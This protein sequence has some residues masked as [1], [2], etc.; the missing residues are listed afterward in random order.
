[1]LEWTRQYNFDGDDVGEGLVLDDFGHIY[2]VGYTKSDIG[3]S[4][5]RVFAQTHDATGI[6]QWSDYIVTLDYYHEYS[7]E[8]A[9]GK[10]IA[11]DDSGNFYVTGWETLQAHDPQPWQDVFLGK[12]D[13]TGAMIWIDLVDTY[14]FSSDSFGECVAVDATNRVIIA[15]SSGGAFTD[16]GQ[17]NHGERDVFIRKYDS[18]SDRAVPSHVLWT[19]QFGSSRNDSCWDITTDL[20]GN[21]YLVGETFGT[22]PGQTFRGGNDAFIRKY[23]PDGTVLWT[24]QFGTA[25]YDAGVSIA[26]DPAGN[27]YVVGTTWG[28]LGS[29]QYGD[30][31]VFLRKYDPSGTLLWT[32]QFGTQVSDYGFNLAI[33]DSGNVYITGWT[34]G[35]LAGHSNQG[36]NDVFIRKYGPNGGVVWTHMFGTPTDDYGRDIEV[37]PTGNVFVFGDTG[38]TLSDQSHHGSRDVFLRKYRQ[39][40]HVSPDNYEPD[41]F[42]SMSSSIKRDTRWQTQVRSIAP[43]NDIDIIRFW[44][45]ADNDEVATRPGIYTFYSTGATDVCIEIVDPLLDES[46]AFDDN[47]GDGG[48]F[49]LEYTFPGRYGG[50]TREHFVRIRGAREDTSGVYTLWYRYQPLYTLDAY[51]PDESFTNAHTITM[52][53]HWQTQDRTAWPIYDDDI[54]EFVA[55]EGGTYMFRLATDILYRVDVFDAHYTPLSE[56]L[57]GDSY[58]VYSGNTILELV[59]TEPGTYFLRITGWLDQYGSFDTG[60]YSLAYRYE[61]AHPSPDRLLGCWHFNEGPGF[62]IATDASPYSNDA[63]IYGATWTTGI[64]GYALSF[65]GNDYAHVFS[66]DFNLHSAVTITAW[67]HPSTMR[68]YGRIAAKTHSSNTSPWVLYGLSLNPEGYALMELASDTDRGWAKSAAPIPLHRWTHLAGTYDGQSIKLYING[69]L[70]TT[71]PFTGPL[72]L[73]HEPFS[74]GRS[75]Y[76]RD[77]F[78]GHID[79]VRLYNYALHP[80]A[81]HDLLNQAPVAACGGPYTGEEGTIIT[82]DASASTD[83][84]GNI[85]HYDWVFGDGTVG[86]GISPTHNY[87]QEG[88]YTVTLTVTDDGGLT[89]IHT[90]SVSIHDTQPT[91]QFSATSL[92]TTMPLTIRCIDESSSSDGVTAW[93]WDFGDGTQSHD[94][95]PTHTYRSPNIYRITLTITE[96]DGDQAETMHVQEVTMLSADPTPPTVTVMVNPLRPDVTQ[97]VEITVRCDAPDGVT[98]LHLYMDNRSVQTWTTTGVHTYH[99]GSLTE[100]SHTYYVEARDQTGNTVRDPLT[101]V[102][103]FAVHPYPM[104]WYWLILA[105][106]AVAGMLSLVVYVGKR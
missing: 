51:E 56:E 18:T 103:S 14:A 54:I 62:A 4:G 46:L 36:G 87:S 8:D 22:L 25:A 9:Y 78:Q 32:R 84:D 47:S 86:T 2:S 5:S 72:T 29:Q 106:V 70:E 64:D 68:G 81:I 43:V 77:Y 13:P 52:T 27:S 16:E 60:P 73:N 58:P 31:D 26:I 74:I 59:I 88:I 96:A 80:T 23:D 98:G 67:I 100:G 30:R 38:G 24:R 63:S 48:N 40:Y 10:D 97:P 101:G 57:L 21:I 99:A 44:D 83:P 104:D 15:G 7:I 17:R 6:A 89:S 45:F 71:S 28:A 105:F 95:H 91:A 49:Y 37:D 69:Q 35:A 92:N 20:W 102:K 53:T 55:P 39:T 34:Q 75:S 82:F 50:P 94:Q 65:N 93:T 1:M 61:P 90:T 66:P 11:I 19:R 12:Y 3:R 76:D 85:Q 42:L 79:D 33:D 41:N